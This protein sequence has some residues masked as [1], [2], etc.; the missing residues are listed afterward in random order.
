MRGATLKAAIYCRCFRWVSC[1]TTS[2]AALDSHL[3][4]WI[5]LH[6]CC[7]LNLTAICYLRC[8]QEQNN[9]VERSVMHCSFV[10]DRDWNV[11]SCNLMTKKWTFAFLSCH[12][13][14]FTWQAW[15]RPARNGDATTLLRWETPAGLP[16]PEPPPFIFAAF[17]TPNRKPPRCRFWS[18]LRARDLRR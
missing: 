6:F 9:P 1:W 15:T 13:C 17:T 16:S 2:S 12:V 3:F 11:A 7:R 18:V 10:C 4:F 8:I 14:S 5:G